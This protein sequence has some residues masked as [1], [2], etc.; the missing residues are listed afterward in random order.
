MQARGV[1]HPCLTDILEGRCRDDQT[2]RILA[3]LS[4][5]LQHELNS[6]LG[7]LTS[8]ADTATRVLGRCRQ[9]LDDI[10]TVE[11]G[12]LADVKEA[13][14]ALVLLCEVFEE[15]TQRIGEVVRGLR[16]LDPQLRRPDSLDETPDVLGLVEYQG[17]VRWRAAT[18]AAPL[19]CNDDR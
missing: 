11:D 9:A 12:L 13:L 15:S 8:A 4:A 17:R 7:A 6:P 1:F 14:A 3:S 16:C 19:V 10:E 18:R 2:R 5:G